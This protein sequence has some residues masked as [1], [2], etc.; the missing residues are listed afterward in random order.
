M[1]NFCIINFNTEYSG[2]NDFQ[3]YLTGAALDLIL[4]APTPDL[5][6]GL[7]TLNT[8]LHH[9]VASFFK[10]VHGP[11]S[12]L[13]DVFFSTFR[14]RKK[15]TFYCPLQGQG[16]IFSPKESIIKYSGTI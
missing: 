5:T 13:S 4:V 10:T 3:F 11:S 15:S 2:Q 14:E 16:T 1:H 6:P 7:Q 12:V 8:H 9:L